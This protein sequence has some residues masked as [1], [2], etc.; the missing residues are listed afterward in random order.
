MTYAQ[1]VEVFSNKYPTFKKM[2]ESSKDLTRLIRSLMILDQLTDGTKADYIATVSYQDDDD[3]LTYETFS[4]LSEYFYLFKLKPQLYT[5]CEIYMIVEC[6]SRLFPAAILEAKLPSESCEYKTN[7]GRALSHI[8]NGLV[9]EVADL[10]LASFDQLRRIFRYAEQLEL[11]TS[12]AAKPKIDPD[13]TE[14]ERRVVFGSII[15]ELAA[16][17]GCGISD[18]L[19]LTESVANNLLY[20]IR[21]IHKSQNAIFLMQYAE[22]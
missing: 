8:E 3:H 1:F 13:F 18:S 10:D 2:V 15:C 9:A 20:Y 11:A 4:H 7:Y 6:Y 21:N 12:D 17:V 22:R 14:G 16:L 19:S 5:L